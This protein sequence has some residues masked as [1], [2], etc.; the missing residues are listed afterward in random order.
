ML[1]YSSEAMHHLLGTQKL[2][3]HKITGTNR[4]LN[5]TSKQYYL[6]KI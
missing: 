4:T 2:L 5:Q 6:Y 3:V 1:H